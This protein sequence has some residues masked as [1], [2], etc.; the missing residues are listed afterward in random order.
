[1]YCNI[2]RDI[3]YITSA[4]VQCNARSF[5][6]GVSFINRDEDVKKE[7][8]I[9]VNKIRLIFIANMEFIFYRIVV[10]KT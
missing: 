8:M 6:S 3:V 1:M 4:G 7:T 9:Y 5:N 10:I 2:K